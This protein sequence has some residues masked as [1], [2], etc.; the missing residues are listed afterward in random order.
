MSILE[1][2]NATLK[3][4]N[5][6]KREIALIVLCGSPSAILSCLKRMLLY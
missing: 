4:K 3:A 2:I 1:Q 5:M 6:T